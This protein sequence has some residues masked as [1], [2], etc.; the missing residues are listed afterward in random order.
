M[1]DATAQIGLMYWFFCELFYTLAT[2]MLKIAIGLFFLRIAV[3]KWHIWI[4]KTIMFCSAV[5]G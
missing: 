3:N 5:L 4:I 1:T 2:S